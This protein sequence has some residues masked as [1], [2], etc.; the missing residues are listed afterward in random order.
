MKNKQ[1]VLNIFA[2]VLFS[3]IS[4]SAYAHHPNGSKLPNSFGEGLLSGFGHPVIGL[5]HLVF[6]LSMGLLSYSLRQRTLLPLAFV[7]S[8]VIGTVLHLNNVNI[9]ASEML[10][11]FSVVL[12]GVA[13]VSNIK[14]PSKAAWF[15]TFSLFGVLHGYAYGE[16]IVGAEAT[17][18]SAY[19][20]GFMIIQLAICYSAYL[21]CHYLNQIKSN[22]VT[23][24]FVRFFGGGAVLTGLFILIT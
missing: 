23:A 2:T 18:L 6:I 15:I 5:D 4:V 19:L 16:S 3:L 7:A 12:L 21:F 22:A 14:L 10:V 24:K 1:A 9:L 17:V 11:A 8:T 20:L 13:M